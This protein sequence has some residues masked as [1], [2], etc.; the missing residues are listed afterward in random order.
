MEA[1]QE[2]Q[3]LTLELADRERENE[4]LRSQLLGASRQDLSASI[5][6]PAR[7]IAE[8]QVS[9]GPDDEVSSLNKLAGILNTLA[10]TIH[11]YILFILLLNRIT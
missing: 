2:G 7:Q 6:V 1:S 4:Q 11:R 3:K 8:D 10:S 5:A 9:I